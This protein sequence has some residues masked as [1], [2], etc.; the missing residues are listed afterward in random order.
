[1]CGKGPEG[2][3]ARAAYNNDG[4]GSDGSTWDDILARAQGGGGCAEGG[5]SR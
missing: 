4:H 2:R 1:V 3:V 5:M